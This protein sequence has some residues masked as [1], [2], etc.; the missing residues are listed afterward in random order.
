MAQN[1][2]G[3]LGARSWAYGYEYAVYN[4]VGRG[5]QGFG[6]IIQTQIA[7]GSYQPLQIATTYAQKFP[8]AGQMLERR[9]GIPPAVG[10]GVLTPISIETNT[11]SCYAAETS[12]NPLPRTGSCAMKEQCVHRHRFESQQH[13]MRVIGDWI[14]FY[15]RRRP[16]QALG[17]DTPDEAFKLA[18]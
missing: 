11:W 12:S 10:T 8:L 18:A 13:A 6:K 9:V 2:P 3:S 17:V 15:N 4:H 5:F 7:P 1:N 14:G 16:H